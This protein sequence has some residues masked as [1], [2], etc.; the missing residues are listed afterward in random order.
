MQSSAYLLAFFRHTVCYIHPQARLRYGVVLHHP[1][2]L[3]KGVGEKEVKMREKGG[4]KRGPRRHHRCYADIPAG[5]CCGARN[6]YAFT[7]I[8]FYPRL[9]TLTHHILAIKSKFR[10]NKMDQ[11]DLGVGCS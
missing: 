11:S 6:S 2:D 3:G 8:Y 1:G 4:K 7:W 9:I 10:L 5:L